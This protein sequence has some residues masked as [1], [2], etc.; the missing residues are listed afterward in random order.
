MPLERMILADTPETLAEG[1]DLLGDLEVVG[2]D[3]ERADWDRYYR[4][5]ALIQVGGEGLVTLVDPVVLE[6]LSPLHEYLASRR[7]ILH[8]LENDLDPLDNADVHPPVVEDTAIAAA[9]LGLPTGLE[10]L[11]RDLLGVELEGDKSA[12]Q[13]AQ[14]EE[15]PLKPEMLT[16][17]AGDVADLPELWDE[18][19]ARLDE[20]GRMAWYAEELAATLA[21]PSVEE[22][23]DWSRLKG[24]GRLD[25]ATRARARRVWERRE[26]L[27]RDTDTAPSRIL[28]DKVLVDLA[29][30]PPSGR[31]DLGRRGVRRQSVREFGDDI[32]SALREP[33]DE[34]LA[35][36]PGPRVRP[37]TDADRKLA[38]RLR[39]LRSARAEELGI[40][41]GVLCPSRTLMGAVLAD[42]TTPEEIREALGLRRW[43]WEQL[44]EDFTDA[45]DLGGSAPADDDDEES[46]T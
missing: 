16:Y 7:T 36:S 27:A 11:L 42:P 22:R 15:R 38:E 5:A 19:A 1:L 34:Q 40:D 31:G 12:M 10:G 6:D 9:V 21:M 44:A 43:Q 29:V 32:V 13:R 37:P 28:G 17:A 41:A 26:D 24:I 20:A 25:P 39:V 23:R 2:V 18:L 14:W 8:A 3:V 45:F 4:A 30:N 33:V 35:R 46:A